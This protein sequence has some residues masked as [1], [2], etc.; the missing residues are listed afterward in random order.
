[1]GAEGVSDAFAGLAAIADAMNRL[2]K[3]PNARMH[4]DCMADAIWWSDERPTFRDARDHWCLRPIFHFRTTLILEVPNFENLGYWREGMRLFPQWPGFDPERRQPTEERKAFARRKS[5]EAILSLE[6]CD[7][8]YRL[9]REFGLPRVGAELEA[10]SLAHDPPDISAKEILEAV[11]K[12]SG[13][14]DIW[15]RVQRCIAEALSRNVSIE[16]I[17]LESRIIADLS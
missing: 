8:G 1:V 2:E 5:Q 13:Q 16:D 9:S 14:A 17:K 10:I 7:L 15:P 11:V 6:L 4:Y 3:Q 12:E